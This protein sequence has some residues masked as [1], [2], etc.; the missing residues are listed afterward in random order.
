[1]PQQQPTAKAQYNTQ[2]ATSNNSGLGPGVVTL[3]H[4]SLLGSHL[5]VPRSRSPPRDPPARLNPP[6]ALIHLRCASASCSQ[7]GWMKIRQRSWRMGFPSV[8]TDPTGAGERG[9]AP[10]L[11]VAA[12][13][14]EKTGARNSGARGGGGY[15]L[16]SRPGRGGSLDFPGWLKQIL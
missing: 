15:R 13:A 12:L 7:R 8:G 2:Q 16:P 1:V 10:E 14:G 3:P 4:Y 11:Q 6:C 5:R 9:E